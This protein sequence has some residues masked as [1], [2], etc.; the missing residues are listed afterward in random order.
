[1]PM[2]DREAMWSSSPLA[3][4]L[5]MKESRQC[6]SHAQQSDSNGPH[7]DEEKIINFPRPNFLRANRFGSF[8][9]VKRDMQD[10][11]EPFPQ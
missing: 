9:S 5:D 3:A 7:N 8:D 10:V 2:F 4:S 6:Q 1:M 11:F